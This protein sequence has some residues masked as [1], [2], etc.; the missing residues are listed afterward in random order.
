MKSPFG[1]IL[2]LTLAAC[3]LAGCAQSVGPSPSELAI[4]AIKMLKVNDLDGYLSTFDITD[5]DKAD[6]L[7]LYDDT[8]I[9]AIVDK[10]GISAYEVTGESVSADGANASVE[11]EV[12]YAD[13]TVEKFN[14]SMVLI[15][16]K[17]MQRLSF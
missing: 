8:V 3:L 6:F 9:K 17:W 13:G 2:T 12:S 11:M 15:D 14:M 10:G 4:K 7:K 1:K 16:G 5:E